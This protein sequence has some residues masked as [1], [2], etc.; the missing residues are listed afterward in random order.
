MSDVLLVQTNNDGDVIYKDGDLVIDN[1]IRTYTYLCLF[2][3]NNDDNGFS[4]TNL[5]WWANLNERDPAYKY[6]SETQYLL[7]SIPLIPANLRRIEKAAKADLQE[8]INDEVDPFIL[9]ASDIN[10]NAS[11]PS[12]NTLKLVIDIDDLEI[13][14][15]ENVDV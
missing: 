13:I 6:R 8:L 12:I 7:D 10:V 5:E 15:V 1:G 3:G 4:N 11:I 2:G 9:I 14:F